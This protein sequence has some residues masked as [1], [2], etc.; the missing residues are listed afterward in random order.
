M[1]VESQVSD[2]TGAPKGHGMKP[3]PRCYRIPK[4]L[5]CSNKLA[6]LLRTA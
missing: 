2:S 4:G 6:A 5:A 1:N 3:S